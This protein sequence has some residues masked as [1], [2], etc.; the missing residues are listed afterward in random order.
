METQKDFVDNPL[1][2]FPLVQMQHIVKP[3][4]D[5]VDEDQDDAVEICN[6]S[7]KRRHLITGLIAFLIVA[8]VIVVPCSILIRKRG[9]VEY[10]VDVRATSL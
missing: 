1:Q 4:N 5:A 3:S 10:I 7:F 6:R 9:R 2:I 8:L